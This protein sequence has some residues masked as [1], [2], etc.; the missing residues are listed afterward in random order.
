MVRKKKRK[1]GRK[2]KSSPTP[3]ALADTHFDELHHEYHHLF[4]KILKALSI[5]YINHIPTAWIFGAPL[6]SRRSIQL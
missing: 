6:V 1:E 2:K 4:N 5:H 3:E